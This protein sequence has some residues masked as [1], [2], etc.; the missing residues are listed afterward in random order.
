MSDKVSNDQKLS[1]VPSYLRPMY[2]FPENRTSYSC[3][4]EIRI[5]KP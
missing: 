2:N 4:P 3:L 1:S 5:Q